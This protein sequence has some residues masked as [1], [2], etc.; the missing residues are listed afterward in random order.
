MNEFT[1]MLIKL[2]QDVNSWK[3]IEDVPSEVD[4]VYTHMM[5]V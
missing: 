3:T 2:F 4:L 5:M 1:H